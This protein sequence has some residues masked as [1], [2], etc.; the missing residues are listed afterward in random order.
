MKIESYPLVVLPTVLILAPTV[1]ASAE[2]PE[3]VPE[4][5]KILYERDGLHIY[6]KT[7][8]SEKEA[9]PADTSA[10][11]AGDNLLE[12]IIVGKTAKTN[13]YL[14]V[15]VDY[16]VQTWETKATKDMSP[17][18][19]TEGSYHENT[20]KITMLKR[21]KLGQWESASSHFWIPPV[22]KRIERAQKS[23][24]WFIGRGEN[25]RITNVSI[26]EFGEEEPELYQQEASCFLT[27]AC[28][29]AMGLPDNCLELTTLRHFR[30]NYV[31]H[32]QGGL[33]LIDEYYRISPAI[34][35]S[36]ARQPE[37]LLGFIRLYFE[38]VQPCVRMIRQGHCREA[39]AHYIAITRN[40]EANHL[41]PALAS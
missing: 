2:A 40:L 7:D 10:E 34:V 20:I 17:Y 16:E 6:T 32:S 38:L 30:D 29:T 5:A 21:T 36:M 12:A 33:E 39:M 28:V 11:A 27:T 1:V 23:L 31:I 25:F 3:Q 14:R 26:Q 19:S 8:V 37:G 41:R 4:S 18:H 15:Q 22:K 9:P 13:K 35:R 24:S